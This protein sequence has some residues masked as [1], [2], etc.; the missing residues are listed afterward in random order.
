MCVK[1]PSTQE[2]FN[3]GC[4]T[5]P[6][7]IVVKRG[8]AQGSNQAVSLLATNM[9]RIPRVPG[10]RLLHRKTMESEFSVTSLSCS[11]CPVAVPQCGRL[12]TL[13]GIP[14]SWAKTSLSSPRASPSSPYSSR[15]LVFFSLFH[16]LPAAPGLQYGW[17][18]LLWCI[19]SMAWGV[20][21][22]WEVGWWKI[23]LDFTRLYND[24]QLQG[25]ASTVLNVQST[26]SKR[27]ASISAIPFYAKIT[28]SLPDLWRS[29]SLS[30]S[31]KGVQRRDKRL[32]LHAVIIC[33]ICV[34]VGPP[35]ASSKAFIEPHFGSFF[36]SSQWS[37]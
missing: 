34:I 7:A 15:P 8:V 19:G 2:E 10:F 18:L 32:P 30:G 27:L 17:W 11:M 22:E 20:G 4:V 24:D 28:V 37:T 3:T 23:F 26:K 35:R 33:V 6:G 29:Q 5:S 16:V 25:G 12:G 9:Q 21:E 14:S 1:V 13:L 36:F 31:R